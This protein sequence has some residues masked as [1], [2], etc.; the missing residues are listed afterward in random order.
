MD[1]VIQ[2]SMQITLYIK[3]EGKMDQEIYHPDF[4]LDQN[5]DSLFKWIKPNDS[6]QMAGWQQEQ[7]DDNLEDEANNEG[8]SYTKE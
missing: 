8:G 4:G 3:A 6:E 2:V 5:T 1:E 7:M